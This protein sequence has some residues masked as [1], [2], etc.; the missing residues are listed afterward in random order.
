MSRRPSAGGEGSAGISAAFADDAV[1]PGFL[2]G[3][4]LLFM[5]M[6]FE[7]TYYNII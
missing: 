3:R 7:D 4:N 5:G 1:F 6:P 2:C